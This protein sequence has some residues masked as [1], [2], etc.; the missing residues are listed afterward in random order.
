MAKPSIIDK[1]NQIRIQK[2]YHS[3]GGLVKD[4][5]KLNNI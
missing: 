4:L 5:T 1:N 3:S 2:P